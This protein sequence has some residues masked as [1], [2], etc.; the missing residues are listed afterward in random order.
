MGFFKFGKKN[1]QTNHLPGKIEFLIVG[2][3]NPGREYENTR[4]NAGFLCLDMLCIVYNSKIDRLKFKSLTGEIA[5]NGHRCLCM[6]PQTFM[7]DS[8]RAV[9]DAAGFYKIPPGNVIVLFDDTSLPPAALRIRRKGSDGGHNGIKSIIYH[10][11]SDNFP[12]IKLGIGNKP[13][14]DCDMKD[15]VLSGFKKDE[16]ELMKKTMERAVEAL[17]FIVD[18]RI[19]EAMGKFN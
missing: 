7:N 19:D 4:H 16:I 8:G 14:P 17:S 13:H 6:K 11:N 9:R 2:L 3:G 5:I 1:K 18:G 10:L 12:R 15:Y